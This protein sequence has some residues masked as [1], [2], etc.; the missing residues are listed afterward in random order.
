L[1]VN[2]NLT[3]PTTTISKWCI[4]LPFTT[5]LYKEIGST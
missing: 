4:S 2:L 3:Q 1:A 5:Y